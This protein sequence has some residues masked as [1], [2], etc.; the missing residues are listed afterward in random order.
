MGAG[1]LARPAPHWL[2]TEP[3][4]IICCEWLDDLPCP[5]V[6]RHADGWRELI[7]NDDGQEQAGP[8]L[9][10]EQLAWA[11]RWWPGGE[12][13]EIGLT[14][15]RAWIELVKLIM[16]RGGCAVMIDYGHTGGASPCHRFPRGLPRRSG[17]RADTRV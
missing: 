1:P 4:M 16:K 6:A 11:D 9:E 8:R 3:V 17:P 14:R 15:D 12:R 10:S 5:V 7:I 2:R 13:A